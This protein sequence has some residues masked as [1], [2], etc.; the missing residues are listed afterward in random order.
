MNTVHYPNL[1]SFLKRHGLDI[2]DIAE[3]IGKTYPPAHQKITR[4]E[5]KKGKVALFDIEEARA[6]IIFIKET[7]TSYLKEKYGDDWQDE[8]NA[9][10]GHID[11]W[12]SYIFFDEVVTNVTKTV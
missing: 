6:I 7:E 3:V 8:W 1:R 11:N 10:W 2:G 9:R 5:T 12:F 4:K